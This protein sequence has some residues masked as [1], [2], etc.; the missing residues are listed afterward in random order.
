MIRVG[1][2]EVKVF[3]IWSRDKQFLLYK[4]M[5]PTEPGV[6]KQRC[7]GLHIILI[8]HVQDTCTLL[9]VEEDFDIVR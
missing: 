2:I 1:I 7:H 8:R 3:L 9:H 5:C 6:D 4:P